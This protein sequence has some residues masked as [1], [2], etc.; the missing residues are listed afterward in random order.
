MLR[1]GGIGRGYDFPLLLAAVLTSGFGLAM[2]AS[3]VRD[4]PG[5]EGS[6]QGQAI[7]VVVGLVLALVMSSLDYRLLSGSAIIF[8]GLG[9]ASLLVVAILGAVQHGGQRWIQIGGYTF[10]PSE[11]MKII[12]II[13]L[14]QFMGGRIGTPWRFRYLIFSGLIALPPVLL[15]YMQP[16]L[17]TAL[18][19][20][21][22]WAVVIFVAGLS[23]WQIGLLGVVAAAASPLIWMNLH[24]YMRDRVLALIQPD[25]DAGAN[26]VLQQAMI[27]LGSGSIWGKGY[28]AGSQTQLHFLRVRHTDFIFSVIGEELGFVGAILTLALLA[29]ICYRLFSIGQSAPDGVGRLIACGGATLIAF[30]TIVNVGMNVGWLPVT[31]LP[32]P[33]ISLGGSAIVA[34]FMAVGLAESVAMRRQLPI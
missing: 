6:V 3:A 5:L 13:A 22:I 27:G 19:L 21:V 33:F 9:I 28:G 2:A 34:Q 20:V 23:L 11:T 26:M 29:F 10:Q 31:G 24:G 8:Y 17:G 16:D 14:A 32:L 25:Q 30:Q 12:L 7:F 1:R 18:V 15:V 4:S